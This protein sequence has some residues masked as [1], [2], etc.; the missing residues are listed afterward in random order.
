MGLIPAW[1][2]IENVKDADLV[3]EAVFEDHGDQEEVFAKLDQSPSRVL[4]SPA[5]P[6]YLNIDEIAKVTKRPQ[7]GLACTSSAGQ[8]DEAVRDRAAGKDRSRCANHRGRRRPPHR[9]G[10]GGGR[11]HAMAS[12]ASSNRM[13]SQRGKQAEKLLFE[14]ALPQQV[15]AVRAKFGHADGTVRVWAIW[16]ALD[17]GWRSRQGSRHQVGNR[18]CAVRSRRFGQKTGKGYYKS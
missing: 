4:F 1:S 8:C 7:D 3:I 16:P 17:I 2:G 12:S 5:T 14:G 9:Q 6:P 13:L 11:R 18:R 10:A 15:D